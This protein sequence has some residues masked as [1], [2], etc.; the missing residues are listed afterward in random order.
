MYMHHLLVYMQAQSAQEL[1]QSSAK[2]L[3]ELQWELQYAWQQSEQANEAQKAAMQGAQDKIAELERDCQQ[4]GD[5][6]ARLEEKAARAETE[7][8]KLAQQ[9]TDVK[10]GAQSLKNISLRKIRLCTLLLPFGWSVL[11]LVCGAYMPFAWCQTTAI[12]TTCRQ[13]CMRLI[14]LKSAW[15]ESCKSA[16]LQPAI[17][18]QLPPKRLPLLKLSSR[19]PSKN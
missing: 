6:A 9:L 10:V 11:E 15:R 14:R 4:T 8:L 16:E 18:A 19:S 17:T 2:Q 3:A 1:Q 7:G 12:V 5:H 13:L